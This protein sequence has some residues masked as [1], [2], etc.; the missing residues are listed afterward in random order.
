MCFAPPA[1]IAVG[2]HVWEHKFRIICNKKIKQH[3]SNEMFKTDSNKICNIFNKMSK[4]CNSDLLKCWILVAIKLHSIGRQFFIFL[5]CLPNASHFTPWVSLVKTWSSNIWFHIEMSFIILFNKS[6][7][8]ELNFNCIRNKALIYWNDYH[9]M[10]QVQ[11]RSSWVL[12]VLLN[13]PQKISW[14]ARKRPRNISQRTTEVCIL[15]VSHPSEH[16]RWI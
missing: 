4:M 9:I 12:H 6:V 3:D 16:F 7:S 8:F 15:L 13:A 14:P 5:Y 11:R 1:K 10:T 2:T